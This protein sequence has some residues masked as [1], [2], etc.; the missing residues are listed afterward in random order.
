MTTGTDG[1]PLLRSVLT[2]LVIAVAAIIGLKV[3]LAIISMAIGFFFTVLFTLG[4]VLLVGWIILKAL[5]HFTRE[6]ET[7]AY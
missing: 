1:F 5:R 2:L 4:P 3:V 7:S 6:P